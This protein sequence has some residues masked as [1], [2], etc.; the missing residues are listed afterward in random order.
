MEYCQN[1]NTSKAGKLTLKVISEGAE[2]TDCAAMEKYLKRSKGAHLRNDNLTDLTAL[3][4]FDHFTSLSLTSKKDLDLSQ[5]GQKMKLKCISIDAP[6][7]KLTYLG[8]TMRSIVIENAPKLDLTGLGKHPNITF[9]NFYNTKVSSF[10]EVNK[11]SKL[12][13][14]DVE[15]GNIAKL[16]EIGGLHSLEHLHLS[17]ND[18]SDLS[19]IE[20]FHKL[21]SLSIAGNNVQSLA[22]IA[23]LTALTS[24]DIS[25]NPVRDL[26]PYTAL[27]ASRISISTVSKSLI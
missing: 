8:D 9:V 12:K 3:S 1:S 23:K 5:L 24:L 6:L 27:K 21:E 16:S 14:L 18:L 7:T 13:I 25:S 11:L 15:W 17:S 10:A 20:H 26:S 2:T 4:F 22:P 19:G